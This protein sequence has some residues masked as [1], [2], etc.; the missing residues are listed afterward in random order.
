[1]MRMAIVWCGCDE[2]VEKPMSLE[3]FRLW[4]GMTECAFFTVGNQP[5][6]G[7]C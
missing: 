5:G 1:M 6:V 3:R 7:S 4:E 2:R